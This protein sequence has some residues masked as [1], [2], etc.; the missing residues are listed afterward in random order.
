[1]PG[2]INEIFSFENNCLKIE[3]QEGGK[4]HKIH[5][6]RLINSDEDED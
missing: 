4:H 6:R 1:M 5:Y 2:S 3:S